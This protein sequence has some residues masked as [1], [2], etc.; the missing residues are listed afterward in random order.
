MHLN[1][2]FMPI[3]PLFLCKLSVSLAVVWGF[4][5][6]VLRRLTFY[7]LNRWYLLGYTLLSFYIP[8]IDIGPML[9]D[10]PAG[11]LVVLQ[12][13]P[14]IG[15][16]GAGVVAPVLR[17]VGLSA[18]TVLEWVLAAGS[19][20]LLARLVV[21]WVSL[22][23]L[24]RKA[25]LIGGVGVKIYQ[26]DSRIT[27]FSFG[28]A[29]YVNQDLH[30]EKEWADIILHEYVHIRQKHTI[31]ILLAELVCI[32]N[33]YNPFAWLIRYS[34]RQ[35]LEFIADRQVL[36]R[37]VD[38]KEYQYHLLKV[39]GAPAYRLANNF[40][41][42]SLK[43]RIVMMNRMRSARV[44]LLKLLFLL[45][46]VGVLLAAFRDRGAGL[47]RSHGPVYVN[48]AGIVITLPE[49]TPLGGVIVRDRVTGL[50]T[51]T[52][53]N[54]FYKLHIP[55]SGDSVRVQLD[56]VK[57][58]YDSDYRARYW[59][60][61]KETSGLL[62]VGA[63][64]LVNAHGGIFIA[65]S[66][67]RPP[68]DPDR[69]DA[70]NELHRVLKENDDVMRYMRMQKDHPEVSLFYTTE[71]K[72]KEIVV[73]TDGTVERYGYPGTPA[74]VELY[75]KYG[76]MGGYMATN[77]P[78]GHLPNSSYLA[79]WAAIGQEAEREFHTTNPNVRAII[80]PGDSRVIAVPVTGKARFY[81]MDNDAES[82]RAGFER[83]YGKLPD[84]VP[85]AGFNSDETERAAGHGRNWKDTAP[86]YRGDTLGHVVL[87]VSHRALYVVDGRSM[88]DGWLLDS[89]P[90]DRIESINII[91]GPAAVQ[92]YGERAIHGAVVVTVKKGGRD[93]QIL[94]VP[95]V[96][97]DHRDSI[98]FVAKYLGDGPL[99]IVDGK[100]APDNVLAILNP[101]YIGS[102]QVLKDS[103]AISRYGEKARNGVI[104]INSKS[105][106]N[107]VFAGLNIVDGREMS[108]DS[109]QMLDPYRV[110]SIKVMKPEAAMALYG[111]KGKNGA[112]VITL[113]H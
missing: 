94:N 34:I 89:I 106:P 55:V 93:S 110:Q 113:K 27:P 30:T 35:N 59:P 91:P 11:G 2:A 53:V 69:A 111:E 7:G 109:L 104:I 65:P 5:Q 3:V 42:S 100:E 72:Q 98:P 56:Y 74:L 16:A 67:D 68:A 52:D 70:E 23:R 82:E 18:W 57:T 63:L 54:G 80:F 13:I 24:R 46:L 108:R 8:L 44:H 37:G 41:F 96:V 12:F 45:P 95:T 50:Q 64:R 25:R 85:K 14:V 38:R 22:L 26:V 84:F 9:P 73:H 33:W 66:F 107:L 86:G 21:R 20:V 19:V 48:A 15:G 10:G 112:A 62:D 83:L 17:P 97:R 60:S 99:Y 87:N 6:V 76:E 92:L 81:D 102:I 61:L 32:L 77:H 105:Q 58:G 51:T 90:S 28:N 88:P 31:D 75:K 71:D 47:F 40:N 4:Y 78:E 103:A 79:R 49:R 1:I 36:D 43:K 101:D 39:V 29:I